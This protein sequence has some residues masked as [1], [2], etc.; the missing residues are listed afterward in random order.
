MNSV[1]KSRVRSA[2]A[3]WATAIAAKQPGGEVASGVRPPAG[4]SA[5][6]YVASRHEWNEVALCSVASSLGL[7]HRFARSRS[8]AVRSKVARVVGRLGKQNGEVVGQRS[9]RPS[10]SHRF[11]GQRLFAAGGVRVASKSSRSVRVH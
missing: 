9:V 4:T 6:A 3:A 11:G 1:D 2:L 7:S 8:E 5:D 10:V